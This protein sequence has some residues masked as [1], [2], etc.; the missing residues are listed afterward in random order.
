[1]NDLLIIVCTLCLIACALAT[2]L[3]RSMLKAAI[4][5]AGAS[6]FLAIVMFLMGSVWSGIFELSVCAGLITV[7]FVSAISLTNADRRDEVHVKDH[8]SRFIALP[9]VLIMAGIVLVAILLI[10]NFNIT[11][12]PDVTAQAQEF[13]EIF[14]NTR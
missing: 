9:F 8:R 6:A 2:A 10:T 11:I 1:M 7:V 12:T 3:F 13:Q 14:W 4:A 5:L